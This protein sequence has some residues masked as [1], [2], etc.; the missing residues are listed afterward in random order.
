MGFGG[1]SRT[2]LPEP[3][4]VTPVPQEEGSNKIEAQRRARLAAADREGFSEHRK[5]G[6]GRGTRSEPN[7]QG[8]TGSTIQGKRTARM[9]Y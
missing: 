2:P 3:E 9:M 1:G 6:Q 7:R 8:A 5:S 4:P